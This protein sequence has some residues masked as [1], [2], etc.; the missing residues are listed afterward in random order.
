MS[1]FS[2]VLAELEA[3][4]ANGQGLSETQHR[5]IGRQIAAL[6]EL[7]GARDP[8]AA[9]REE[10]TQSLSAQGQR[11]TSQA[12]E[13]AGAAARGQLA[14]RNLLG[15]S[16]HALTRGRL[17]AGERE[18]QDEVLR[19]SQQLD[20]QLAHDADQL[21]LGRGAEAL[22]RLDAGN[23]A[24]QLEGYR[25]GSRGLWDAAGAQAQYG[26]L[27]ARLGQD[28]RAANSQLIGNLARNAGGSLLNYGF[29]RAETLNRRS[30]RQALGLP[31]GTAAGERMW[32]W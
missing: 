30:H 28:A 17:A 23:P 15:S 29:D 7:E 11:E 4:L 18:A 16:G 14:L 21:L 1:L 27:T 13:G 19:R 22:T 6:R 9:L 3:K 2:E 26:Q 20:G 31:S 24:A 8:L 5:A 10:L 12:F 25:A 32:A